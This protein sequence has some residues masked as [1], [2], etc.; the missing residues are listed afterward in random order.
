MKIKTGL[1]SGWI[2]LAGALP[3]AELQLRE[4]N[5]DGTV[6]QALVRI[7]D[8]VPETGLPLVFAFHGHGGSMQNAARTFRVHE[9]WPEAA[10]VYMQGLPTPGQL[11]DREGK[12]NGWNSS[13]DDADNCDLKFFDTVYASLAGQID[14]NRVY[15]TGHSNGGGFTYSLWSARGNL[16]AA[17]APSAAAASRSARHLTPKPVL[18]VAGEND[19]LVKYAW[20]ERTMQGVRKLNGC[21]ESGLSWVSSGDLTGTVYPSPSGTPVVTLIHPGGHKFPSEAPELIVRFFKE[22]SA[23]RRPVPD[24]L[25]GL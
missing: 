22:S 20:Q 12:R 2:L 10:V 18:L 14:S 23:V 17:M 19:T 13:P 25:P 8:S 15:C 7:P 21:V 5:V 11:T 24:S 1:V 9:I 16:F 6:R 3:A 4:W